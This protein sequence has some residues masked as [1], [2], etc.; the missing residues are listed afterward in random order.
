VT[1]SNNS[2]A[3]ATDFTKE[4]EARVVKQHEFLQ[5]LAKDVHSRRPTWSGKPVDKSQVR[6][7]FSARMNLYGSTVQAAWE[8]GYAKSLTSSSGSDGWLIEWVALGGGCDLCAERDGQVFTTDTLPG[9]PGDGAF[10]DLCKGAMNCR[11]ALDW[12]RL[13]DAG[14]RSQ[15]AKSSP[16]FMSGAMIALYPSRQVAEQLAVDDGLPVEEIHVTLVFLTEDA[17]ETG[18]TIQSLIRE[19]LARVAA[20]SEPLRGQIAGTG[21]FNSDGDLRPVYASPDV[22]GLS[23]LREEIFAA[24]VAA[25]DGL[26]YEPANNHGFTPHMTLTYVAA[27][28]VSALPKLD[29]IELE[30]DEVWLV[31][32]GERESFPLGGES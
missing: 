8:Q 27:D 29:N 25:G 11:C 4:V 9:Y 1:R 19:T 5:D 23:T 10:G 22:P 6:E 30:F 17:A 21:V 20:Q 32:G 7:A 24:I 28:E 15:I 2:A 12:T 13:K 31:W 16:D 18:P 3:A 26:G 14:K